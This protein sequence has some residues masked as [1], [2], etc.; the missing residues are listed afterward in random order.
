MPGPPFVVAN[1][2]EIRLLWSIAGGL[3]VNVLHGVAATGVVV[4]QGLANTI[5]SAIK[6][7]FGTTV[8]PLMATTTALVRVGVR[9]RRVANSAE[10]IDTGAAVFGT[11]TGDVLPGNVCTCVTLRTAGSGKSFRGRVYLSGFT[12][13]Q[14]DAG[15]LTLAA[16]NTQ[17]VNFIGGISGALTASQITLCVTTKPQERQTIVEST[18]H[19]D[20]TTTTRTISTQTAKSGQSSVATAIIARDA[21]WQSQRRRTNGRGVPPTLLTEVA[22]LEL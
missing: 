11:G 13:A 15:G 19:S 22:R 6:T 4:N 1:T 17:S 18:T 7:N 2:V 9:D 21:Q 5:G 8:G 16:A 3:G 12:E 14:N 10:F 20:G